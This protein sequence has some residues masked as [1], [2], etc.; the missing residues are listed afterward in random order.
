VFAYSTLNMLRLNCRGRESQCNYFPF[1]MAMTIYDSGE[2]LNKNPTWHVE[3]SLWKAKQII[4]MLGAHNLKPNTI[5]EVG[6]GAGE[7][8]RSL[9]EMLPTQVE[10]VGYEISPQAFELAKTR[11]NDRLQFYLGDIKDEQ[12]HYDLTIL[13]DVI[14]HLEDYYSFL[15]DIRDRGDRTILHIPLD[16]CVNHLIRAKPLA[17]IRRAVGH[18]HSFTKESAFS[19]LDE[20]G[21]Q[22]VD[23]FYTTWAIDFPPRTWR[24]RLA[25]IPRVVANSISPDFTAR[26]LG[27]FSLLVLA[28]P[29]LQC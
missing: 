7:I 28:A 20:C 10:L 23:H 9:Q 21:F 3:D 1:T 16:M 24:R 12:R 26:V 14:E 6:C 18:I 2:Y 25:L 19:V 17:D 13:M 27:G 11:Q 5:C 4:R 22:V 15:R 29:K 8:L